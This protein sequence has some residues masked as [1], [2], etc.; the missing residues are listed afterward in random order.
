M[1]HDELENLKHEKNLVIQAHQKRAESIS[2]HY[3]ER[4][5]DADHKNI[6]EIE[7]IK[8]E[9]ALRQNDELQKQKQEHKEELS[10]S[11]QRTKDDFEETV[12]NRIGNR[13]KNQARM[14]SKVATFILA[15][16]F[17]GIFII[18]LQEQL[19]SWI[20]TQYTGYIKFTAAM[21]GAVQIIGLFVEKFSFLFLGPLFEKYLVTRL[22]QRYRDILLSKK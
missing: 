6:S 14:I 19:P 12:D 16:I 9:L 1:H 22:E 18:S 5:K 8:G 20:S 21:L 10:R 13:A 17:V 11:I 3:E 2:K 4:L 7:I 15:S